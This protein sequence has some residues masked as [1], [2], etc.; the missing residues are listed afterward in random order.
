[1]KVIF[2][3]I[4]G[5][6]NFAKTEARAPGGFIG[7]AEPSVKKL[8]SIVDA[9][10]AKLVLTSTWKSEWSINQEE[11]TPD[12]IYLDK[13]LRRHGMH[14]L[15]KTMDHIDNRGEGIHNWL[16]RHTHVDTWI[17]LDDDVFPD[18]EEYDILHHLVQTSFKEGGL[19][20]QHVL[21]AISLLNGGK[22]NAT[23]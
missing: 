18:Y 13:K 19:Q 6:L 1:M 11:C 23:A 20:E 21:Q 22:Q 5:V 8:R 7:I 3:D 9:T 14:I 17:V 16:S 2:L 12:G 4:D 10:G 15:D